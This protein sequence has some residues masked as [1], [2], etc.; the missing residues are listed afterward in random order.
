M[1]RDR[2]DYGQGVYRRP[3]VINYNPAP[4]LGNGA[5]ARHSGGLPTFT[6][7]QTD[8]R[9]TFKFTMVGKDPRVHLARP[10]TTVPAE[11]IPL[12]LV[13][14]GATS[15]DP[16]VG[17]SCDRTPALTR[18]LNSPVVKNARWTFGGKTIG[19][20]QYGDAF[21][22]AEF[23]KFTKPGAL[24]PGY[25]V[26]L[27]FTALPKQTI[28]VPGADSAESSTSCGT[29]M[30]VGV[31]WLNKYLRT[32][33]LPRLASR[34]MVSPRTFP[35]FLTTNSVEYTRY[36]FRCCVFG[37]HHAYKFRGRV[38][39]Y[40]VADYETSDYFPPSANLHDIEFVSHEIA[41]WMD[42]PLDNN[43]TKPWGNVGQVGGCQNSLE[44]GDPLTGKTI[45][46]KIGKYTYHLQELAFFSWF[47][48]QKKSIGVNG[49][50]SDNG[51][52]RSPAAPCP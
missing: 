10:S 7:T 42:D 27:A 37:F 18:V 48:H 17:N 43:P 13:F 40:G 23:W 3:P 24:N 41:E 31:H 25:H 12:K 39:T 16:T 9:K 4:M 20:T 46:R 44:V 35:L 45:S 30:L 47:Y 33:V 14:P 52:F 8:G 22:R 34:G 38:Q 51:T 32:K 2:S 21:R 19:T 26:K 28:K 1:P 50:Y 49:W 5:I 36:V 6:S 15:N 11:I 29:E